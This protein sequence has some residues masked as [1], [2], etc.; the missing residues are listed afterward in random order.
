[1]LSL[2]V[3]SLA[4]SADPN[5]WWDEVLR[6]SA[7]RRRAFVRVLS[8]LTRSKVHQREPGQLWLHAEARAEGR[9]G[10]GA[11]DRVQSRPMVPGQPERQRQL[12]LHRRAGGDL[13]LAKYINAPLNETSIVDNASHGINAVLRSVPDFL[14]KK[15]ILYLDLA[16]GEV[17]RW[18][19][20]AARRPAPTATRPSRLPTTGT[21]CAR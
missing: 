5:A 8:S 16:Y 21:R 15:G 17:K 2:I 3:T 18:A 6:G 13:A 20:W 11:C 10:A 19:S 7:R 9:R 4:A 1:M 12:G 14:A